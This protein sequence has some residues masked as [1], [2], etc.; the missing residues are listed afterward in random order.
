MIVCQRSIA[1]EDRRSPGAQCGHEGLGL[2]RREADLNTRRRDL[3]RGRDAGLWHLRRRPAVG[4]L[5]GW[6]G[7]ARV[8]R[9]RRRAGG[10]PG[11]LLVGPGPDRCLRP[12]ARRW[13]LAPVVPARRLAAVGAPGRR[14]CLRPECLLVG[15][16]SDRPVCTLERGRAAARM[17]GRVRLVV[18]RLTNPGARYTRHMAG[19]QT[20]TGLVRLPSGECRRLKPEELD[21][22]D[23]LLAKPGHLVWLDVPT[24]A[25]DDLLLLQREFA[26]HPLTLEDLEKRRQRPKV[27]SYPEQ[28]VIVTYEAVRGHAGSDGSGSGGRGGHG[29]RGV[30]LGE[31]HLI[32]GSNYVV[33]V[34]WAPS[35]AIE[36]VTARFEHKTDA[37]VPTVGGLLYAI[38]DAVVDGY[39][40]LLDRL[41]DRIDALENRIVAG[42][43]GTGALREVLAIKREL[44]ELRRVLAPQRDMVNT[45]LRR[46][47]AI[48][49][50]TSL[51][52]FQDLYDHL[53][54]VL[55]SLDLY[56]DLVAATLE[57][58]LSVTSNNLN[59]VMKRLTAITVIL[60]VPTLIAGVYGMNFHYMPE[61]SWPFGYAAALAV[62]AILM[63]GAA[64]FFRA[65]DWF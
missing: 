43:Q 24:P 47:M 14:P 18:R 23:V 45:L 46:D 58:N 8:A 60:M 31:I 55:D 65:R 39:F 22:I 63:L 59:A 1:A 37:I 42:S 10:Q 48:V 13:P 41:S 52:Y 26:L 40:P 16:G 57:A 36:E 3:G 6:R 29:G 12:R 5:L 7:V 32:A 50:D 17:V 19:T 54:R 34:R 11:R 28:H 53:I 30:K 9:P 33:S 21:E 49:D 15:S 25:V 44:L 64:L 56:R 20:R 27:D 35:P 2:D 61:L 51:P 38:L 4:H 62:M